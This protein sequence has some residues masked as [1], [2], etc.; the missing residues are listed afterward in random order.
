LIFGPAYKGIPLVAA[1]AVSLY[2]LCGADI[3]YAFNRKE[4]KDHGEG[5]L[6]VGAPLQGRI[7]I[8][9]D[10]ITAGTAIRETMSLMSRFEGAKPVG[11]V[12]ALDRQE[13]GII[14]LYS[15]VLYYNQRF[16]IFDYIDTFSSF[17]LTIYIYI[18]AV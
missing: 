15:I 12:V 6:V 2:T 14:I 11:V 9:D 1:T 10:V 13:K 3:P 4:A 18:Y 7:V 17:Y 5:G 16:S 8:L